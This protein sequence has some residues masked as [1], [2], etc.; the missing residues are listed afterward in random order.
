MKSSGVLRALLWVAL[1]AAPCAR[2]WAQ[3]NTRNDFARAV[4]AGFQAWDRNHNHILSEEEVD[5]AIEDS[6]NTGP[7]AAALAALKRAARSTNYTLPALTL[8]N[9]CEFAAAPSATNRPDFRSMFKAGL[10]RITSITN[11]ELF[12]SGLPQLSTVHQGRMGDCFCLAPLGAMIHRDPSEVAAL[13]SIQEDGRVRV[14][15]GGGPVSVAPPTDA[16]LAMTA[17]NSRDGVWIN[18]YEK[19]IAQVRNDLRAPEK[20]ASLAIDVIA[21]GGT[22]GSVMRYLTGHKVT[23]TGLKF[24][25]DSA[26]SAAACAAKLDELRQKL[27]NAE[28]QQLLVAAGTQKPTTPGVTPKHAYALLHYDAEADAVSLWNPHGNNFKPKGPPGL[29]N[30][31]PMKNGLLTVPLSEFAKQFSSVTF[32]DKFNDISLKSAEP[33]LSRSP[34]L[35]IGSPAPKWK[36]GSWIQGGPVNT[37]LPGRAYLVEFWAA[38]CEPC[39]I[40]IPRLN[41]IYNRYKDRG[42]TVIGQDCWEHNQDDVAPFVKSMGDK[43]TFPLAREDKR[44]KMDRAWLQAAGRESV[45]TAFLIDTTGRIAWMGHPLA[46]KELLI[47][48]VLAGTYD[49]QKN[50]ADFARE[51]ETRELL[52]QAKDFTRDGKLARAEATLNRLLLETN[53][54]ADQTAQYLTLRANVSARRAQWQS[55]TAD[56]ARAL[57][58][59]PADYWTWDTL[60]PLLIQSGNTADCQTHCKSMLDRF[61]DTTMPRVAEGTAKSC[62]L[63]ASALGPDDLAAA[64]GVADNAVKFSQKGDR[65]HWRLMTKGLAEYRQGRF[66]NAIEQMRLSQNALL[67]EGDSGGNACNADAWFVTAMARRQLNQTAEARAALKNG[68]ALVRQKLPKLDGGDLGENWFDVLPAYFLMRE[69]QAAF[70]GQKITSEKPVAVEKL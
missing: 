59:D 62:L 56:L 31:Y 13:F 35:K 41:E 16:E 22:E 18:L 43:M 38:W 27:T 17:G 5:A 11:H 4:T 29:S 64:A 70:G 9:I 7:A 34:R 67:H 49:S 45:P 15:F 52:R 61:R 46:L 39:R 23:G 28:S 32:E 25:R 8:S 14:E 42:L 26:V 40:S 50:A 24:A 6:A 37:F 65:M 53:D 1:A 51:H 33:E 20:R 68:V 54:D 55:A 19:A 48:A 69:A 44:G 12:A 66:T 21:N 10:R 60:T 57:K 2:V 47:E 36:T 58:S 3:T 30:G 63:L